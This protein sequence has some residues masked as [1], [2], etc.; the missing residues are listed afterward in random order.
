MFLFSPLHR[1]KDSH[2]K[3][4]PIKRILGNQR[5]NLLGKDGSSLKS[6]DVNG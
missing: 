4:T 2:Q 1:K 5:D 3:F 6:I